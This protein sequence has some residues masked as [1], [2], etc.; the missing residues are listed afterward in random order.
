MT[1]W[2]VQSTSHTTQSFGSWMYSGLKK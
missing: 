2:I 1:M